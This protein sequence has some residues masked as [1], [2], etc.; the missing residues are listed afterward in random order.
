MTP[1]VAIVERLNRSCF[2]RP[3]RPPERASCFAFGHVVA[4]PESLEQVKPEVFAYRFLDHFAVTFSGTGGANFD[5]RSTSASI[6]SVV[7]V[8]GISASLHQMPIT[9]SYIGG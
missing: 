1:K 2:G 4:R 9:P 3:A 6:V 8:L 5:S 7:R